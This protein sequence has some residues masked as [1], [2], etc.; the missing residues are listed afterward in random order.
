MGFENEQ[1]LLR[2]SQTDDVAGFHTRYD[3]ALDEVQD[4][5]GETHPIFIDGK[6]ISVSSTF[7][8]RSP[9][10]TDLLLGRFQKAG[11]EEAGRAVKA[12]LQAFPDWAAT[13]WHDRVAIFRRSAELLA[14]DKYPLA[15]LMTHENGKNRAEAMADVDEAI[16]LIR[17][18]A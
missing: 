13:D 12:A 5:L 11:G 2:A 18:Y 6:E 7:A 16:D 3:K 15:A 14:G 10:N 1:T 17:W 8:D 9:S 4:E